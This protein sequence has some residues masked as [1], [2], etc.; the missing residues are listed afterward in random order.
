M[1]E[2]M[3]EQRVGSLRAPPRLDQGNHLQLI[4][5]VSANHVLRLPKGGR[6]RDDRHLAH[7]GLGRVARSELRVQEPHKIRLVMEVMELYCKLPSRLPRRDRPIGEPRV[8]IHELLNRF[9]CCGSRFLR[10]KNV[11]ASKRP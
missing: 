5:D 7:E 9:L 3:M 4:H 2:N 10:E 11:V 1:V 6:V 8:G